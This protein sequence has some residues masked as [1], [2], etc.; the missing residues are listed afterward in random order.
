MK[1]SNAF[2]TL[3]LPLTLAGLLYG[4]YDILALRLK[5][6]DAYPP[7]SSLRTDPLGTKAFYDG[8]SEMK[9]LQVSRNYGPADK[10]EGV[11]ETTLLDLGDYEADVLEVPV[12]AAPEVQG[13]LIQGGRMVITLVGENDQ[14]GLRM[15]RALLSPTVTPTADKSVSPTPGTGT[16]TPRVSYAAPKA[17]AP[18]SRPTLTPTSTPVPVPVDTFGKQWGVKA[19]ADPLPKTRQEV[20][21]Q[22]KTTYQAVTVEGGD[23]MGVPRKLPWH[24]ALYFKGLDPSWKVIYCRGKR[25][26]AIERNIGKGSLLILSDS[27]LTSNEAM[28]KDRHADLLSYLAGNRQRIVFDETHLGVVEEEN[29]ATLARK[30][31]LG[32]FALGLFILALLFV[33]RYSLSLVPPP[34]EEGAGERGLRSGKD[35]SSGLVNLLK[36]NIPA[37]D[38]LAVAFESWKKTVAQGRSH[39]KDKVAEMEKELAQVRADKNIHPVEGYVRMSR[40]FKRKK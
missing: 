29:T 24:S 17:P 5:S 6:G 20:L 18:T 25:P 2:I 10:I 37:R 34:P 21:D 30:Y 40:I 38:I 19:D 26:V 28:L 13:Y 27:Y 14:P 9:R 39:L 12:A 36:R 4:V 35:G 16:A 1:R 7:Y 23:G 11:R 32:G 3:L 31:G 8:L 15:K 33:W 22:V